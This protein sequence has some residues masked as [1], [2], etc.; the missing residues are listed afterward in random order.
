MRKNIIVEGLLPDQR[1]VEPGAVYWKP[2]VEVPV[3]YGFNWNTPEHLAGEAYDIQRN[4]E[5]NAVSAELIF[6]EDFDIDGNMSEA[7][8]NEAYEVT[9]YCTNLIVVQERIVR[10]RLRTVNIIPPLAFPNNLAS[11]IVTPNQAR[12]RIHP[13]E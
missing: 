8:D 10:A 1:F 5:T 12:A 3:Y 4:P 2:G 13:K 9:C 6:F 11:Q 7:I